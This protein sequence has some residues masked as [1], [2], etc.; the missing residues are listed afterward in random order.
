MSS[1]SR[2]LPQVLRNLIGIRYGGNYI[3]DINVQV[4][5]RSGIL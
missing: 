1:F 5:A 3:V 4:V 2:V